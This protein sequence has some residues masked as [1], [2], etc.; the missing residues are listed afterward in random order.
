MYA[1]VMR[2]G[3]GIYVLEASTKAGMFRAFAGTA[4]ERPILIQGCSTGNC[5]FPEVA[6]GVT[7]ITGGFCSKCWNT[8]NTVFQVRETTV[9][10]NDSSYMKQYL[11]STN[12]LRVGPIGYLYAYSTIQ[13]GY[14]DRIWLQANIPNSPNA[15]EIWNVSIANLNILTLTTAGCKWSAFDQQTKDYKGGIKYNFDCSYPKEWRNS[16]DYA[17]WN[18]VSASC[19]LYPC[20]KEMKARV[21]NGKFD[22][23]LVDQTPIYPFEWRI[24]TGQIG[25]VKSP[26]FIDGIRYDKHNMS[27]A[28]PSVARLK[29]LEQSDWV[30]EKCYYSVPTE[31]PRTIAG[32]GQGWF[33]DLIYGNCSMATNQGD[34][35]DTRSFAL[36]DDGNMDRWW[37][38]GLYNRGNA[39]FDT[40]TTTMDNVATSLTDSLRLGSIAEYG[41]N[42]NNTVNGTVWQSAVCT[43]FNWRW[44]LFPVGLIV[45]TVLSLVLMITFTAF[46]KDKVPVWK[47]SILPF[48][49]LERTPT[50]KA[51]HTMSLNDLQ[52]AAREDELVL[53]RNGVGGWRL[54][55]VRTERSP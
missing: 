53:E 5:T 40:I 32:I 35:P 44:L 15:L 31:I 28:P 22:E 45:L 13:T 2:T 51:M 34:N 12:N 1:M 20:I 8:S 37:L 9:S 27:L 48:F 21:K 11:N 16:S 49:Y 39:T 24:Q 25:M 6:P 52:K 23:F 46:S 19:S 30:L 7:H 18:V 47:S 38:A 10:S 29:P 42:V 17:R 41:L 14:G 36:C 3:A 55:P 4:S 26:C 33:D 50:K 54:G 43:D